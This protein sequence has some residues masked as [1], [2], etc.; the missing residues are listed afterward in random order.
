[1]RTTSYILNSTEGF[2]IVAF[3]E[4]YSK[5][6]IWLHILPELRLCDSMCT[7]RNDLLDFQELVQKFAHIFAQF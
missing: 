7:S 2:I 3:T 6:Y 5:I 4:I 1:M